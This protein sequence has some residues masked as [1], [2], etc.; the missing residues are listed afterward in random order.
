MNF[1]NVLDSASENYK[2]TESEE[3]MNPQM[4]NY[5]KSKLDRWRDELIE[6]SKNEQNIIASKTS[7]EPD[8]VDEAVIE[9]DRIV[10]FYIVDRDV[11]LLHKIDMA[12]ERIENGE[13][14]YCEETGNVIGIKRLEAWPIANLTVEVQAKKEHMEHI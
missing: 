1:E 13:Y 5:F 8:H 12:L 11:D 14:G 10:D 4:L 2:P 7:R 3:Y 6:E 9:Q